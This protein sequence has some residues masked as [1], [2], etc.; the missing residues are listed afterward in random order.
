MLLMAATALHG[1]GQ[2]VVIRNAV[3]PLDILINNDLYGNIGI[4]ARLYSRVGFALKDPFLRQSGD[5]KFGIIMEI[6]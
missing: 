2:K 6:F 5:L 3:N 4:M 1:Q